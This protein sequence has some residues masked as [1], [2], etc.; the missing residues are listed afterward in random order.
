MDSPPPLSLFG[1][2]PMRERW[3]ESVQSPGTW[4]AADSHFVSAE[5]EAARGRMGGSL[6]HFPR[7][8]PSSVGRRAALALLR[9]EGAGERLGTCPPPRCAM[10]SFPWGPSQAVLQLGLHR[11]GTCGA[12]A[13]AAMR[14]T[15]WLRQWP[16]GPRILFFFW[17][18][19]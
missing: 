14:Y 5:T 17:G 7:V 6:A 8:A 1:A 3:G 16:R 19:H 18:Q 2:G 15:P 12:A 13:E 9:P 4:G 10:H 11:P